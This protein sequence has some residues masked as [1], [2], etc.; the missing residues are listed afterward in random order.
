MKIFMEEMIHTL[1]GS[2]GAIFVL[3]RLNYIVKYC[4][5]TG[6]IESIDEYLSKYCNI[7]NIS[8]NTSSME[9]FN[10]IINTKKY[11]LHI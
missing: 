11:S 2:K 8:T 5:F 9:Q 7:N 4:W 6:S 3:E 10:Y 1:I